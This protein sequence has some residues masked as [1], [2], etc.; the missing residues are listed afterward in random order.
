MPQLFHVLALRLHL[1][2]L[3]DFEDENPLAVWRGRFGNALRAACCGGSPAC[4]RGEDCIRGRL[5][6]GHRTGPGPSGLGSPPRPYV[7]R[8]FHLHGAPIRAGGSFYIDVHFFDVP[9]VERHG[10]L[11]RQVFSGT[12]SG[13]DQ[14]A[15]L[16]STN[17]LDVHGAESPDWNA[18]V[19]D[20]AQPEPTTSGEITLDFV[21]PTELVEQGRIVSGLPFPLLIRRLR[22]RVSVLRAIHGGGPLELDFKSFAN[23][24]D[25][26]QILHHSLKFL[27]GERRSSRTGQTH[28]LRGWVGP[29]TYAG[30]WLGYL[31]WLLAGQWTG[32]GEQTVFGKGAFVVLGHANLLLGS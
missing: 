9:S 19:F 25:S 28:P 21:S 31:P 15:R 18:M 23:H 22:D 26:V 6:D 30:P 3:R 7:F 24:A 14:R 12:A 5:F 2:A 4:P 16:L 8:C 10:A 27:Q 1:E 11:L 32:V 20:L 17:S 13:G 29:V